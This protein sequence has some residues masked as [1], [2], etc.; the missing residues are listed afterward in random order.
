MRLVGEGARGQQAVSA[1]QRAVEVAMWGGGTNLVTTSVPAMVGPSQVLVKVKAASVNPLD[2]MMSHSYGTTVLDSL[3]NL[4]FFSRGLAQ[5]ASLPSVL[6]RDFSGVVVRGGPLTNKELVPG[7]AVYGATFPSNM[8]CHQEYVVVE[9]EMLA[10]MP[11]SLSH[12]EAASIPYAGLTAWSAIS[13]FSGLREGTSKGARVLLLGAGGG[14]G[15]LA[16]QLLSRHFQ[17]V[18]TAVVSGDAG[19]ERALKCGASQVLDYKDPDYLHQL[20]QLDR[21]D[22]VLD[23]AGIGTSSEA[24]QPFLSLLRNRG[25]LVSLSSPLL[26]KTDSLGLVPGFASSLADLVSLNTSSLRHRSRSTVRWAYFKPD[27]TA[28]TTMAWL[29]R[30][31]RL[32]PPPITV[33]PFERAGEAYAK[34]EAGGLRG[35]VVID[36]EA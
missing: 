22:V 36:M 24:V 15:D 1:L 16:L 11:T 12:L 31:G 35:K 32:M 30:M 23:S 9:E 21:F 20:L 8:G 33:F 13:N 10:P 27:S 19:A 2:V 17:A 6:G 18:V 5:P 26:Q 3:R 14:V 28:L 4:E 25:C 34:V 29:V 7:V